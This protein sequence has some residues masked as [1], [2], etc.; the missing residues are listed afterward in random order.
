MYQLG[1][2]NNQ[3]ENRG[4]ENTVDSNR[5]S[6][7]ILKA[8]LAVMLPWAYGHGCQ[9]T[10]WPHHPHNLLGYLLLDIH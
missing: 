10:S 7:D 3:V 5:Y 4:V 9:V 8:Q 1:K 6:I 2:V